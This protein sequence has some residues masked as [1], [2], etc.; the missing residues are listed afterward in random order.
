MKIVILG[1]EKIGKTCFINRISNKEAFQKSIKEY[2]KTIVSTFGLKVI[3]KNNKK[4]R[5]QLWDIVWN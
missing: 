4:F 2:K 5:F 1:I 3:I